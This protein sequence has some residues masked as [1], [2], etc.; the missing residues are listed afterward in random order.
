MVPQWLQG[1]MW[2]ESRALRLLEPERFALAIH[3]AD[4][5]LPG[6]VA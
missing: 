6:T 1:P 4:G 5:G 3:G 2:D